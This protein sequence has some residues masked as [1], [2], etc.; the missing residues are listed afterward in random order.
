VP[1][2]PA[3]LRPMSS[4][5][6][7]EPAILHDR[8]TQGIETWTGEDEAEYRRDARMLPDGAVAWRDFVF[9]GWGNV[10]GG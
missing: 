4:F 6:P 7:S 2:T 10:L 9:N 3:D 5:N 1:D 8:I